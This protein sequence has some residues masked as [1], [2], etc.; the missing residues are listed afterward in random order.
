LAAGLYECVSE[1]T[2]ADFRK[3]YDSNRLNRLKPRSRDE[4]IHALETFERI[5]GPKRVAAVSMKHLDQF[6]AVR[7][8]EAGRKPKSI[9]SPYTVKKELSAIRAALNAAHEWE[10]LAKRPRVP[11]V[12]VAEAH[13]IS[14][15]IP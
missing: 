11:R 5:V 13:F 4:A 6:V 7:S 12:K 3:E 14:E 9:V 2:W 1:K 8:L 10:Y 15:Q